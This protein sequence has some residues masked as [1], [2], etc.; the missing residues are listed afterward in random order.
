VGQFN[1]S[2]GSFPLAEV[3]SHPLRA[4]VRTLPA[5]AVKRTRGTLRAGV[6]PRG[7]AVAA[8]HFQWGT[9]GEFSN[10]TPCARLPRS[11][12]GRTVVSVTLRG[13]IAGT[14]YY[15]RVRVVTAGGTA[16]GPRRS[17]TTPARGGRFTFG[18]ASVS[19]RTSSF[20]ANLERVNP[21]SLLRPGRLERLAIYLQPTGRR[22]R[23]T[24]RLVLYR[25]AH[26]LPGRLVA[27]S[28]RLTFRS[29]DRARWYSVAVVRQREL[30]RG[31][32]WIGAITGGE[33]GVAGWR[34][35]DVGVRDTRER[36]FA[37]G[38][39]SPFRAAGQDR[40]VMSMYAVIGAG[41]AA[42]PRRM[43]RATG[44]FRTRTLCARRCLSRSVTP[45]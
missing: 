34:Y 9:T 35:A 19:P 33:A 39:S 16:T 38:A 7:S 10:S 20:Q 31:H 30:D 41:R 8:C 4:L 18:N 21:Y 5:A 6:A 24:L 44:L 25:D 23:Q 14:T 40:A 2:A 43:A 27:Q 26:G 42:G 22:G 29:S 15:Y 45:G 17:F 3:S 1:S 11:A 28:R 12:T 36:R 32:Y 13:L 37:K